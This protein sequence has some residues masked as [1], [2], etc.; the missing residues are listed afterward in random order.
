M[1]C[2]IQEIERK[3]EEL[4]SSKELEVY[5]YSFNG[6]IVYSYRHSEERFKRPIKKAYKISIHKSYRE[7]GKVKKKQYSIA[8]MGYYDVYSFSLEDFASI[9]IEKLAAQLNVT[10][11]YIY[12]LVYDKLNPL[13]E[14]IREEYKQTEEYKT[15]Q[16]NSEIIAKYHK[17]ER[18][19][20]SK[21]NSTDFDRCYDVF[22]NLRNKDKLDQI[23]KQHE[24]NQEY[25]KKSKEYQEKEYKKFY[26][27][28]SYYNNSSSYQANN[29]SNYKDSDKKILKKM[30]KKLAMEFHPDK[31][32]NSEESNRAMQIINDLKEQWNI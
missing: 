10:T 14:Q 19:F 11:D 12:E 1:F 24:Q 32:N 16:K 20:R 22:L 25:Q 7:N 31:N 30:Y 29:N 13:Y 6:E 28:N 18:E 8:T 9:K 21:Y 26:E 23:K 5:T 15:S 3:T 2:V 4:G 27:Q 17:A